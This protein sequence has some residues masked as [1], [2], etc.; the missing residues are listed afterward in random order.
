MFPVGTSLSH[1]AG[2]ANISARITD[3]QYFVNLQCTILVCSLHMEMNRVQISDN[4]NMVCLSIEIFRHYEY[5]QNFTVMIHSENEIVILTINL[6][7]LLQMSE[8]I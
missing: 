1:N 7:C 4:F 5:V 6:S 2:N 8:P 3:K